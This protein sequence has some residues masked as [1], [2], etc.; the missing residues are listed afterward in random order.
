MPS[1]SVVA[2]NQ[3]SGNPHY[4]LNNYYIVQGL[5]AQASGIVAYNSTDD[6]ISLPYMVPVTLYFAASSPY[7]NTARTMSNPGAEEPFNAFFSLDGQFS[8]STLYGEAVP[9]PFGIITPATGSMSLLAGS[10][11]TTV[12]VSGSGFLPNQPSIIGW[13]DSCGHMTRLSTFTTSNSARVPSGT[14]FKVPSASAGHYT[15]IVT[16]YVNSVFMTFQHT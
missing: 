5:N 13:D 4:Q 2:V 12:Q 3:G 7:S 9:Y 11:G 1:S 6:S 14:H 16:D 8:D 10:T 15:I